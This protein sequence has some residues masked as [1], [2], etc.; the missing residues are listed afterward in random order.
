MHPSSFKLIFQK[1]EKLAYLPFECKHAIDSF[2]LFQYISEK[3]IFRIGF[4]LFFDKRE[5]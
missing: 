3:S 1:K 2:V 5:T 4:F